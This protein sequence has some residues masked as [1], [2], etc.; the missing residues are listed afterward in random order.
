MYLTAL[1]GVTQQLMKIGIMKDNPALKTEW[2][3][4]IPFNKNTRTLIG[5]NQQI[6]VYDNQTAYTVTN[7]H[8]SEVKLQ[9]DEN[10]EMI[11]SSCIRSILRV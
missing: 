11:T 8:L 10:Y 9:G 5:V 2:E 1:K 7:G 6:I 4:L 3:G